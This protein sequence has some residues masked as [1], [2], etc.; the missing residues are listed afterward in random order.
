MSFIDEIQKQSQSTREIMFA[1]CVII[2]V[3][4]V[5]FV[6]F[7][8]FES[9]LF[10]LLNPEEEKQEI[11]F[12]KQNETESVFATIGQTGANLKAAM[13]NLFGFIGDNDV[14]RL[15][16]LPRFNSEVYEL[17]LEGNKD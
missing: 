4:S 13:S 1:L 2:T 6:W 16:S 7:R 10:V 9:D 3:S 14:E 11:F 8:S 15:E 12:A 5:G 17:P